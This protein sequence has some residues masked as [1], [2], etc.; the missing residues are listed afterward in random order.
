MKEY[1]DIFDPNQHHIGQAT[2]VQVHQNGL[3]H[4][5]FHCWIVSELQGRKYILFQL[6]HPD[7]DIFPDLL[8][9]SAAG[10][11]SVG[12][13]PLD[14]V[15]ELQEELGIQVEAEQL[16]SIGVIE[17]EFSR[18][19][20]IDRE[21]CH[22]FLHKSDRPLDAYM[23]QEDELIGLVHIE[24]NQAMKLFKREITSA[25]VKGLMWN[26]EGLK[27]VDLTVTMDDFVPHSKEYYMKV[28]QSADDI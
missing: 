22:V 27:E 9:I 5:T 10:H 24:L 13:E 7:K 4:Q 11:L 3:W 14:G 17:E 26:I 18:E 12:E 23:I 15:R 20:F 21:F 28:L 8:D 6:R 2:R 19:T 25:Q 16:E 1:L